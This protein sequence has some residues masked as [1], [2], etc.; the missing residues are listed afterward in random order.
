L[1]IS[2]TEKIDSSIGASIALSV[3]ALVG[4]WANSYFYKYTPQARLN[5]AKQINQAV[6]AH[7]MV[8]DPDYYAIYLNTTSSCKCTKTKNHEC[9]K[10]EA[11][12]SYVNTLYSPRPFFDYIEPDVRLTKAKEALK[13]CKKQLKKSGKLINKAKEDITESSESW[14]SISIKNE[15]ETRENIATIIDKNL[16]MLNLKD[17]E[18]TF[19]SIDQVK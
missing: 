9:Q 3:G 18:T 10:K 17:Q 14:L 19:T 12:L 7:E 16:A 6:A 8:K 2:R 13:A 11:L 4:I 1:L 5:E 15:A